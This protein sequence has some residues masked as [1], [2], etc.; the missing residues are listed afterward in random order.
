[1]RHGRQSRL[2]EIG[3]AGQAR[4]AGASAVVASR[5][6]A[7]EVEARYLAGA[8]VAR[9]CVRDEATAEAARSVDARARI[10]VDPALPDAPSALPFA[11]AH[12]SARA[13]ASGAHA[14]LVTLRHVL[15]VKVERA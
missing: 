3:D 14:A 5:G 10:E 4:I 7:A 12:P 13:V 6:L 11:L 1:M 9:L 2:R 15:G 8:G